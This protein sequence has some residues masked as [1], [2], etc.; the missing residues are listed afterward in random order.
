MNAAL[1][2]LQVSK[3][4]QAA[5]FTPAQAEALAKLLRDRQEADLSQLATK[6]D[7]EHLRAATKAD[8]EQLRIATKADIDQLRIATRSDLSAGL[9]DLKAELLKWVITLLLG[10]VAVIAALVKLL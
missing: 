5:S 1:D 10:Q 4:L 3:D 9:A 7:L 6:T 8:L 2:T